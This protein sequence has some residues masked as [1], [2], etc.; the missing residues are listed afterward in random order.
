VDDDGPDEALMRAMIAPHEL[1]LGEVHEMEEV[2]AAYMA[3][4]NVLQAIQAH[5]KLQV[6]A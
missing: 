3:P 5:F 2:A 6:T 1:E 4:A